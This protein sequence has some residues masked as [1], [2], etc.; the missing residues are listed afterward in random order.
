MFCFTDCVSVNIACSQVSLGK[1]IPISMTLPVLKPHKEGVSSSLLQSN[2]KILVVAL[3]ISL[4]KFRKSHI[5]DVGLPLV[6]KHLKKIKPCFG[7]LLT[8]NT[9]NIFEHDLDLLPCDWPVS[10]TELE[11]FFSH[12]LIV[13]LL[14]NTYTVSVRDNAK[15]ARHY[16]S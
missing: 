1:E 12:H 13:T 7:I 15:L 9:K 14:I 6:S 4:L 16:L 2:N 5:V 8:F 10:L 3:L 11:Q